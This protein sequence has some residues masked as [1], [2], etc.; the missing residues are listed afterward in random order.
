MQIQIVL[1]RGFWA[2]RCQPLVEL[3]VQ[4]WA[5]ALSLG[6]INQIEFNVCQ[7]QTGQTIPNAEQ[8]NAIQQSQLANM[9]RIAI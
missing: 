9:R 2:N 1:T 8:F 6:L 4:T 5:E 7:H 3:G